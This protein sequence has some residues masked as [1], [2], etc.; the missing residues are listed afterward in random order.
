MK[1]RETVL[2]DR[3]FG[4]IDPLPTLVNFVERKAVALLLCEVLCEGGEVGDLVVDSHTKIV[5]RLAADRQRPG[6]LSAGIRSRRDATTG[7]AVESAV[8]VLCLAVVVLLGCV[9]GCWWW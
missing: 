6:D 3:C 9:G 1:G 4:G 8:W 7:L 2:E 5:P